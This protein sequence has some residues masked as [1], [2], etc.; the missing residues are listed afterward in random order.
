MAPRQSGDL[1]GFRRIDA[2]ELDGLLGSQRPPLL[3]DVR[4][5]A[6]FEEQPG[7]PT[8]LPVALDRDPILL[9]DVPRDSTIAAYCL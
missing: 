8:A 6:A 5:G 7:I 2:H 9:P 3:L 4:R 1:P